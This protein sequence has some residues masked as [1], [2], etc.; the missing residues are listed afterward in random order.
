[1]MN[2]LTALAAWLLTI[3]QRLALWRLERRLRSGNVVR[4]KAGNIHE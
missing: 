4:E 2:F 1:M 3:P